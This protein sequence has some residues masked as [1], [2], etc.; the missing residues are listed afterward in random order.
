MEDRTEAEHIGERDADGDAATRLARVDYAGLEMRLLVDAEAWRLADLEA[1]AESIKTG[2]YF[3]KV[4]Y[5]NRDS[6]LRFERAQNPYSFD[7]ITPIPEETVA[8][9]HRAVAGTKRGRQ[10]ISIVVRRTT[11]HEGQSNKQIARGKKYYMVPGTAGTMIVQTRSSKE[12][13]LEV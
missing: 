4:V 5:L 1:L 3:A 13:K 12:L 8:G 6:L 7:E 9:N 11:H 10:L 2:Q